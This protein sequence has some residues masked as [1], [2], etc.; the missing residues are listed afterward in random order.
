[1]DCLKNC[2]III[3][4][5]LCNQRQFFAHDVELNNKGVLHY[6]YITCF[7][8]KHGYRSIHDKLFKQY[9]WAWNYNDNHTIDLNNMSNA[10]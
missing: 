3:P 10:I 7:I 8:L 5:K 9:K 2:V 4:A 6:I 1:M